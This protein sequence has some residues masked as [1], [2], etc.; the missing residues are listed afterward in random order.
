MNL[1]IM[2]SNKRQ[3]FLEKVKEICC[4][5]TAKNNGGCEYAGKSNDQDIYI[6]Y[7]SPESEKNECNLICMFKKWLVDNN[8]TVKDLIK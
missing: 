3:E 5:Y 4:D 2:E 8:K 1:A 7:Y 6:C